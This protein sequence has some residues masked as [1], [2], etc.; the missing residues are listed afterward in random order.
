MSAYE[1]YWLPLNNVYFDSHSNTVV[2]G[3]EV[4]MHFKVWGIKLIW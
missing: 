2:V 4:C 1:L 3:L